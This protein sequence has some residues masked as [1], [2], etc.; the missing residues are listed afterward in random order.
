MVNITCKT[1]MSWLVGGLSD[2]INVPLVI[3][4]KVSSVTGKHPLL[5]APFHQ[6]LCMCRRHITIFD[7]SKYFHTSHEKNRMR[8]AIKKQKKSLPFDIL[9]HNFIHRSTAMA[10]IC[11]IER[12]T[13]NPS[14]ST[15]C[16]MFCR[17]TRTTVFIRG[18][19]SFWSL[20]SSVTTR[21][22]DLLCNRWARR[23]VRSLPTDFL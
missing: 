4:C 14:D 8:L 9:F 5:H 13:F 17:A 18:C 23:G 6:Y 19:V 3:H 21:G 1:V 16:C 12:F 2:Y 7:Y 20:W 10:Q 15:V 22:A 11:N